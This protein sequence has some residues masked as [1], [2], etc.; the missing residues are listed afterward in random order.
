MVVWQPRLGPPFQHGRDVVDECLDLMR[1]GCNPSEVSRRVGVSLTW[2][3]GLRNRLGGVIER[4]QNPSGRYLSR[5]EREELARLREAGL[6]VR[7]IGRRMR[8]DAST[9]SRELDR[10]TDP[11]TGRYVPAIAD[12]QAGV[13]QKRPKTSKLGR[14]PRLRAEVQQ[15]LDRWHSPEQ[16]AG[17]LRIDFPDDESMRI[18]HEAIYRSLYVYPRGELTR[19]LKAVLRSGRSRRVPRAATRT[20]GRGKIPGRVSIHDRPDEV[21]GRLIPGHHEGDL[22]KGSTASNSA[23]GTI[24]E[25]C[26]GLLTLLHLPDGYRAHQVADA[27]IAQMNGYPDSF[28]KSLTWDNGK[29]MSEHQ[30]IAAETPLKVYFADPHSPWQRGTNENTNGLLRQYLPKGSDLSVHTATDLAAIADSLNDR[31]RKRLGYRTPREV[32]ATLNES[33]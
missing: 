1:Q 12:H 8:R 9:I 31:P 28:L 24:V 29:E 13:R 15:R 6:G 22:V 19:E 30:R 20:D 14:C 4:T 16:I 10:N 17:R 33:T 7:E 23:V 11:R 21:E 2:S 5:L 18:S 32:F 26:S 27:I 3:Y 25:R